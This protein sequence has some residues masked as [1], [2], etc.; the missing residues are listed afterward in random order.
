MDIY[1]FLNKIKQLFIGINNMKMHQLL[2]V[3]KI[4]ESDVIFPLFFNI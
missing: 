3:V 1:Y 2:M 4:M